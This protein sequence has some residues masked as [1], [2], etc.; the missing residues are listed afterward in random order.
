VSGGRVYRL[1]QDEAVE[2]LKDKNE[3]AEP[4]SW[5]L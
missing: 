2:V 3:A 4:Y 5:K 1:G